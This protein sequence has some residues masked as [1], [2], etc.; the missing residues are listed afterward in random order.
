MHQ[1][2]CHVVRGLGDETLENL[3]IGE[4]DFDAGHNNMDTGLSE[5][6]TSLFDIKPGVK[7]PENDIQ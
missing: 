5:D 7:L 4:P 3:E 2:S 1:R 6:G